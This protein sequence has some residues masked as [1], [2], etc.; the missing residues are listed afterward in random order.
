MYKDTNLSDSKSRYDIRTPQK[1]QAL[2]DVLGDD[3]NYD[4]DK[5][6]PN[7]NGSNGWFEE[8]IF[9]INPLLL[10]GGVGVIAAIILFFIM[11]S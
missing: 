7:T 3:K 5:D 11:N 10:L 8:E 2:G 1:H 4:M 6:S 9:G